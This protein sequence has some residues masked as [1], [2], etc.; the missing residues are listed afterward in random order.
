MCL[1]F[2]KIQLQWLW[3]WAEVCQ[4]VFIKGTGVYSVSLLRSQ[5]LQLA[6]PVRGNKALDAAPFGS[7][8]D[9]AGFQSG[10]P[11]VSPVSPAGT[12]MVLRRRLTT[13]RSLLYGRLAHNINLLRRRVTASF[14]FLT[15]E[16]GPSLR[17]C[18]PFTML[19]L[20]WRTV[21]LPPCGY[22]LPHPPFFFSCFL[23]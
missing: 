10:P 14:L 5:L 4:V 8:L 15:E 1:P 7:T 13:R 6:T 18:R 22:L 21:S 12:S 20:S 23:H 16:G 3:E 11:D 9:A 2:T 17:V 19:A